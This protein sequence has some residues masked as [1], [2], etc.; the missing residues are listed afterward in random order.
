M[1]KDLSI[2]VTGVRWSQHHNTEPKVCAEVLEPKNNS[3][4][5]NVGLKQ[6]YLVGARDSHAYE[7]V[8]C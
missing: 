1:P 8:N 5:V 3:S 6:I 2:R 4:D 7:A